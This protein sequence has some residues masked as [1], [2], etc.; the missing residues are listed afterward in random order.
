MSSFS[1]KKVIHYK[2]YVS[3]EF[4]AVKPPGF[5]ARLCGNGQAAPPESS[6]FYYINTEKKFESIKKTIES[7]SVQSLE[8][9]SNFTKTNSEIK[10]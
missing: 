5:F 6:T 10:K 7:L 9:T 8:N 4:G 1:Q 2:I 3:T